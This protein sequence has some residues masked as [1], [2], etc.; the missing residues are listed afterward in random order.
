MTIRRAPLRVKILA[1][2]ERQVLAH[3]LRESA[4][5]WKMVELIVERAPTHPGEATLRGSL[6]K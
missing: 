2:K 6:S 4:I 1:A 5:A 3:F